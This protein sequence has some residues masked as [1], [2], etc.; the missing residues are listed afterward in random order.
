MG[1]FD[2]T[3]HVECFLDWTKCMCSGNIKPFFSLSLSFVVNLYVF[4]TTYA[5]GWTSYSPLYYR[6][7][8]ANLTYFYE[9]FHVRVPIYGEYRFTSFSDYNTM[10]YLYNGTFFPSSPLVN[11]YAED[12][13][14]AGD[15]Q[16]QLTVY[17]RPNI[18]YT[19]VVTTYWSNAT[20]AYTL[21]AS[22]V[23]RVTLIP[24]INTTTTTTTPTVSTTL[25]GIVV[26]RVIQFHSRVRGIHRLFFVHH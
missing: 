18:T 24:L 20:G 14:S 7:Y 25:P 21:V 10:A 17:L 3:G 4:N 2:A 15:R 11:Y 13:N 23:N 16:F 26:L 6:P 9:S 5:S 22:G 12:D 19:L 8:G 1:W